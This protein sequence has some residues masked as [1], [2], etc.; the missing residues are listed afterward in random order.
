MPYLRSICVL[1]T[2][3]L[4][5]ATFPPHCGQIGRLYSRSG[6]YAFVASVSHSNRLSHFG[7]PVWV[8]CCKVL[9]FLSLPG[10]P[11]AGHVH[12]QEM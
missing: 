5:R 3:N 2:L 7:A 1:L 8:T 11:L 12:I 4:V 10:V 6:R 9:F